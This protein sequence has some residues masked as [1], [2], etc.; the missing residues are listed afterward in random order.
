MLFLLISFPQALHFTF[1]SMAPRPF[2][3]VFPAGRPDAG[4]F[5]RETVAAV[6]RT[7]SATSGSPAH[8]FPCVRF[9]CCRT[10]SLKEPTFQTNALL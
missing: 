2:L 1:T 3:L 8:G 10:F 5:L 6:L 9:P 7:G 4:R